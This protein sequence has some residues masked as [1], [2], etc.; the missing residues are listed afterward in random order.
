LQKANC[1]EEIETAGQAA[2]HSLDFTQLNET[3][4][5]QYFR[6][7]PPALGS[8]LSSPSFDTSMGLVVFTVLVS[9]AFCDVFELFLKV[10]PK[11][12]SSV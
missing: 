5:N 12:V 6:I 8:H 11:N 3:S 4:Q 2:P 1:Q 10:T 9:R 7:G